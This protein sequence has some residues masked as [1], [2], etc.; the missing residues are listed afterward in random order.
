MRK[1]VVA[2]A[3]LALLLCGTCASSTQPATSQV[4]SQSASVVESTQAPATPVDLTGDWKQTNSNS[5]DTWQEAVIS[6]DVIE[7]DWITDNGDTK[8]LYWAGSFVAPSEPGDSYSWT[9]NNDHSKTDPSL[10]AA[11]SDIKEFTY[12]AGVLSWDVTMMGT[13]TTV[14]AQKV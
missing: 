2:V 5:A 10:L 4:P 14:K 7:I 8:S 3:S 1:S 13:T 11:Q 9:S 6:G 12:S